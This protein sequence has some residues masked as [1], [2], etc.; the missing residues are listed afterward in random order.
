MCFDTG[1]KSLNLYLGKGVVN[2]V[3]G[4][5]HALALTKDIFTNYYYF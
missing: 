4:S 5:N 3:A 1:L 2:I